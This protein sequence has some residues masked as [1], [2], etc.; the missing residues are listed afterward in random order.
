[1]KKVEYENIKGGRSVLLCDDIIDTGDGSVT[2][3]G[4]S[5]FRNSA[6]KPGED[7]RG[8]WDFTRCEKEDQYMKKSVI[9]AV[10]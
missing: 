7:A 10:R 4:V 3:K 9:N 8:T 5:A 2:L 6:L 1:M